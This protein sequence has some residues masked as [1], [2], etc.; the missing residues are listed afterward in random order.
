M[1]NRISSKVTDRLHVPR[2][3][4]GG[5][6][7]DGKSIGRGTCRGQGFGRLVQKK[8]FMALSQFA[9]K[10]AVCWG[11]AV[12]TPVLVYG[13]AAFLPQAG[14]YGLSGGLPGEQ[15]WPHLSLRPAGGYVVWEDNATDGN[16]QGVSARRLDGSLVGTL[17]SFRVNEIGAGDQNRPQVSLLNE[18]GAAFVWQG[19]PQGF[20]RIYARFL[21]TDGTWA[22]GD[23]RVNTYTNNSQREPAIATLAGGNVVVTW[24]SYD[25]E[26]QGSLWGVFAQRLNPGGQPVGGEFRVNQTT[27]FNQR[28][29]AIAPLSDGR[30]VVVWITEHQ[31]FENSV[32][33]YARIFTA[34]GVGGNEFIVNT[35]TN[36]CANPSVAPSAD[37]GFMVAWMAKDLQER[38]NGWDA[39]ARPFSGGGFGG[40][41]RRVNTHTH[42]DQLAPKISAVGSDYLVVWTSMAQDGSR[43]GIYGQYLS[44][45]GSLFGDEFRVNTTTVSQQI[46]PA[47]A[48]DGSGRFLAVWTSF[49]GGTASFDLFGQRYALDEQPLA[50]PDAPYVTV[51]SSSALSITWPDLGGFDVA[52]YEVF[53]DGAA[54]ATAV[55]TNNWWTMA[56]LAPASSHSFRLAYVLADGR[57]SP[58]SGATSN[59]T[60]GSLTYSGIPVEWM[61]MYFGDDWPLAQDD[62]DGDGVSNRDEFRAGTNPTNNSSVLRVRLEPTSQGAFL[63]WNTQPGLIYQVQRAT[64]LNAWSNFGGPRFAA[65]AVD[66]MFVGLSSTG[67]YRVERL[68]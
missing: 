3:W 13:Q 33:V 24:S 48:S 57:R 44:A 59:T 28:S 22:T 14:E 51:L 1:M 43:E 40:V 31:R 47:V 50:P 23:V 64:E 61:A 45:D 19:G 55:V 20:Q 2:G 29:S 21:S 41:A 52:S 34:N 67:Y 16:G 38:S 58:L 32:D 11:L 36:V 39:F 9:R 56:G 30:F 17:S 4:R 60:Y 49:I 37:G 63:H 42:G 26:S 18:G 8:Y 12:A 5:G 68:R 25:Q 35:G 7:A 54:M 65:G 62:S 66:S 15:V 10:T 6:Q 46:Q 27:A 53:A